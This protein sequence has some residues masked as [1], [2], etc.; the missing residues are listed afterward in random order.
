MSR[1]APGS[2]EIAGP[3]PGAQRSSVDGL[4]EGVGVGSGMWHGG[5]M[6][7]PAPDDLIDGE[8]FEGFALDDVRALGARL[9]ECELRSG[10]LTGGDLGA[11]AWRGSRLEAVRLVG[12]GLARSRW[13]DVEL[14][15]C[16]LSGCELYGAQLKRVRFTDCVLDSVNLRGAVLREVTFAGCQVRDLDLGSA[17]LG[18][19]RW[20][21]SRIRRLDLS[22]AKLSRVDLRGADVDISR[23]L[24]RLH[25]AIVDHGQLYDLAPALA[26]HLGLTVRGRG[27]A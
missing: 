4:V 12:V 20:A 5:R 11:S 26:A 7:S 16:A 8:T 3:S 25:G 27:E 18:D 19:V 9:V 24:D 13:T 14:S 21:G 1:A 2:P 23:G 6:F 17:Q 22:Q 15:G 10:T